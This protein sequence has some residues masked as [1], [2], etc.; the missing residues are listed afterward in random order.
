MSRRFRVPGCASSG[1]CVPIAT[2]W[3]SHF[4][5]W[6]NFSSRVWPFSG[7]LLVGLPVSGWMNTTRP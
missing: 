4:S 5:T 6:S 1:T 3:S 2:F 7:T